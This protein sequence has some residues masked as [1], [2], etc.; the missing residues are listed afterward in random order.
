MND[1]KSTKILEN[2]SKPLKFGTILRV[3]IYATNIFFNLINSKVNPL[4]GKNKEILEEAGKT[5][6][7]VVL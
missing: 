3:G 7:I 1:T 4:I 6:T 2:I 5:Q